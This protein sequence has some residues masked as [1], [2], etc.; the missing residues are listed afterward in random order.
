[1]AQGGKGQEILQFNTAIAI[2]PSDSQNLNQQGVN[3]NYAALYIGSTGDLN[4]ILGGNSNAIL[5]KTVPVGW[6]PGQVV[7]VKATNTTA[8]NIIACFNT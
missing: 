3:G 8:S 7:Q 4:V 5:F 2:S 1:M 6:F